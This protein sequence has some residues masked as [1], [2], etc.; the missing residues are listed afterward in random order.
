MCIRDRDKSEIQYLKEV[1]KL[2]EGEAGFL[3]TCN[4]GEG[5]LKVGGD[6]A[7]LQITPTAKEDV[8]KRQIWYRGLVRTDAKYH[9]LAQDSLQL[10]LKRYDVEHIIV[11]HTIFK[12]ISTFYDGRVI[13]VNVDNEE[14]RKK[15]RGR[16][17][18]IDGNTYLVVGDKGTMRKL[19]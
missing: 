1:F 12:D 5:L 8:Y 15:K 16:A 17:L 11:G 13:G 9:P 2:S 4:K 3:V 18:L 10:M 7:I 6:T 14:N 19:F